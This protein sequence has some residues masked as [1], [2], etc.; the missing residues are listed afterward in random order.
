MLVNLFRSKTPIAIFSLPLIIAVLTSIIIFEPKAE[1]DYIF[2]WHR[3]VFEMIR[4]NVIVEFLATVLL[5]SVVA[6]QFN[7]IFNRHNFFSKMTYLPGLIYVLILATFELLHFSPELFAQAFLIFGVS[8]I[9]KLRRQEDAKAIIFLTSFYFGLA[10]VFSL[11]MLPLLVVPWIALFIFRPFVWREWVMVILGFVLPNIYLASALY[12]LDEE[13][14]LSIRMTRLIFTDIDFS[15]FQIALYSLMGI[16]FLIAMSGLVNVVR[17]EVVRFKKQITLV[18]HLLWISTIIF[19]LAFYFFDIYFF[20]IAI[21][22]TII[23]AVQ[24]LNAK[25]ELVVNILSVSWF[26]ICLLNMWIDYYQ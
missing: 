1:I 12:L 9:F 16:I 4:V 2:E 17:A 8:N 18:L 13:T 7:T 14:L 15:Y 26:I 21:P 20:S 24:M 19:F 23:I 6:H 5:V 10:S 11:M 22:L 3:Y 25:N